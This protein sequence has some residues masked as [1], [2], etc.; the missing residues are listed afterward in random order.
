MK[1][2]T[3]LVTAVLVVLTFTVPKRWVLIP[4]IAAACMVPMDQRILIFDLDFTTLRFVVLAGMARLFIRGEIRP[5]AW[6]AF[7]KLLFAWAIIGAVVYVLQYGDISA[8]IYKCGV[9]YDCLGLYWVF[10]QTL[11][12]WADVDRAFLLLAIGAILSTP[13]ILME[14]LTHESLYA[15]LGDARDAFHRGRYRCSGPFP[16]F[17]MMGLFWATVVPVFVS[18]FTTKRSRGL[19]LAAAIGAVMCVILSASSTPVMALLAT[20]VF[21]GLWKFRASGKRLA[22]C[23]GVMILGMH[24]VMKK[25]VWHLMCRVNVFSGST[26]WHRYVLFDRFIRHFSEWWMLGCRDVADWGVYAGDITNQYVLEGVRGGLITLV[27]F[28]IVIIKA[29]QTLGSCSLKAPTQARRIVCWGFCVSI[30]GHS[31]AFWGVSYFGQIMML[32]YLTFAVTGFAY[33]WQEQLASSAS[34]QATANA[35]VTVHRRQFSALRN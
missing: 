8:V 29:V 24:L 25:P 30:L 13:L 34:T 9:L 2:E 3:I 20:A 35:P 5:I 21:G 14:R 10:R 16:H 15:Y 31:V 28:V 32:M 19:F 6:N 1:P 18:Y 23:A 33:G 26:G 11:T 27:M 12:T 4:F 17:I 22:L 7:D